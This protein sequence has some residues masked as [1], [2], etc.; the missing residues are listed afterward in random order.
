MI[1]LR[2]LLFSALLGP[3]GLS[4]AQAGIINILSDT[5][6]ATDP[7]FIETNLSFPLYFGTIPDPDNF[8]QT[9]GLFPAPEGSYATKTTFDI[10]SSAQNKFAGWFIGYKNDESLVSSD[11]TS[12]QGGSLRFWIKSGI[13]VE[14]GMASYRIDPNDGKVIYDD[15]NNDKV[16]D[17]V[18]RR[19][20]LSSLGVPLDSQWHP[21][22]I[23][24]GEFT[25]SNPTLTPARNP[26]PF[27]NDPIDLRVMKQFFIIAYPSATSGKQEVLVDNIRWDTVNPGPVRSLLVRAA[28]ALE[29]NQLTRGL[30][31]TYTAR[32]FDGDN[33]TGNEVDVWPSWRLLD[34]QTRQDLGASFLS[35]S[36]AIGNTIVVK[37][38]GDLP[39]VIRAEATAGGIT[40][41]D[42]VTLIDPTSPLAS[43][44]GIL[45]E[46]V[47]GLTLDTN[48]KLALTSP[49]PAIT[50]TALLEDPRENSFH[51][52]INY[53]IPADPG[54]G[55]IFVHAGLDPLSSATVNL[56]AFASG[57][58]RFWVKTTRD[59]LISMRSSN[60]PAGQESKVSLREFTGGAP[61]DGTWIP[62]T[63]PMARFAN[64][65]YG[66]T[67]SVDLSR[68]KVF[69]SAIIPEA[70]QG[71][72]SLDNVRLDKILPGP[73]VRIRLDPPS[74]NTVVNVEQI[75]K[76]LATD[77]NGNPVDIEPVWS[78]TGSIGRLS[79]T[80]GPLIH[81]ISTA[82]GQEILTATAGPMSDSGTI[83]VGTEGDLTQFEV[84]T[85]SNVAGDI[86]TF[87]ANAAQEGKITL[88]QEKF[89]GVL[90]LR[91]D[92]K[93]DPAKPNEI[94]GWFVD[95]GKVNLPGE[96]PETK[97]M[98]A[99]AKGFLSFTI[100]TSQDVPLTASIR[101]A[102]IPAE[103]GSP[104]V[105]FLSKAGEGF[106]NITRPFS[107]FV[108]PD[109]AALDFS[110]IS[111][112]FSIAPS[113]AVPDLQLWVGNVVWIT[114]DPSAFSEAKVL[115]GLQNKQTS[116]GLVQSFNGTDNRAATYDQGLAALSYLL[117]S[118]RTSAE[119]IFNAFAELNS[120]RPAGEG[121]S[122]FA[123]AYD[124][125][126]KEP[127]TSNGD[128]QKIAG[129]NAWLLVA[130]NR[131]K[132]ATGNAS[133]D[134]L[135]KE[136]A[137]WIL[138][139]QDT[140]GGI[141][142][143]NAKTKKSTEGNLSAI[144]ALVATAV[145]T[146][147]Q[148]YLQA[149]NRATAWLAEKMYRPA[150]KRFLVGT[151]V[152]V[153]DKALDVYSWALCHF[154]LFQE[155]AINDLQLDL[156]GILASAETDFKTSHTSTRTNKL[157]EGFDFNDDKDAVWLEGTGQMVLAYETM[158]K[159]DQARHFVDQLELAIFSLSPSSQGI[160]Y[161]SNAGTAYGGWIMNDTDPA[162]SSM[163][164]YLFSKR[165]FNPFSAQAFTPVE[166]PEPPEPPPPPPPEPPP[167]PVS[168]TVGPT[169]TE[170]V[171]IT[172]AD[173][174]S[175]SIPPNSVSGTVVIQ[176]ER[177]PFD[178]P[179]VPDGNGPAKSRRPSSAYFLTP[180]GIQF[181]PPARLTLAYDD[182]N[183]DGL[184]D[185][186][187]GQENTL[188]I[189][190]W[191]GTLWEAV[192]QDRTQD[193]VK[194]TLSVSITHFSIYAV[195]PTTEPEPPQPPVSV[196]SSPEQTRPRKIFTPNGDGVNE[197]AIFTGL[198]SLE[199]NAAIEIFDV[200]GRRIQRLERTDQWDGRDDDGRLVES[201]VYIYQYKVQGERLSG[202]IG[203]AR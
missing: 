187:G 181:S 151:D 32:G 22:T 40:D 201:G 141:F 107:D 101:S 134:A 21:V 38:T 110:E 153:T 159:Q 90:F 182:F 16:L 94:P 147:D 20:K 202:V 84:F 39:S 140:D 2:P 92:I 95:V 72:F 186:T 48:S 162:V 7:K 78:L 25:S 55:G 117:Y 71:S 88:T 115:K 87:P 130:L 113:Q 192:T 112:F 173:G 77:S 128:S 1:K 56:S 12:F 26:S 58:L 54:F 18:S 155:I 42:P 137:D 119:K 143:D 116:S 190:F 125:Q 111:A 96:T 53:N 4:L 79:N 103:Q 31:A 156:E 10:S 66:G 44:Y 200:T 121:F 74:L 13:D 57:S 126:T 144:A 108:S 188:G 122:G 67:G 176:M 76:A 17:P 63:I 29:N 124:A 139:L 49:P 195:F 160:P 154:G 142:Y 93:T 50:V 177:V 194:N 158:G 152:P 82:Q 184:D 148:A 19:F 27:R 23:P 33:R 102:N 80:R 185:R 104:A 171:T 109:Q 30:S 97:D 24:I 189:F 157:V 83:N 161:A 166:P 131:Y 9:V 8:T 132:E 135:A 174:S 169:V 150:E 138:S 46:S 198:L 168:G 60:V 45:S 68:V 61:L 105:Q 15:V 127:L 47:P 163:A 64:P 91:A 70:A 203:V 179:R 14:V 193:F 118:D 172:L 197:T 183:N 75:F 69:F 28:A 114:T 89:D 199:P 106:H 41:S 180:D 133:F 43:K 129:D 81:F 146:K 196:A 136:M 85:T 170:T 36:P 3:F 73:A 165:H 86:G 65:L 5:P 11:I 62:V 100:K 164:W 34:D 99:Y 35:P 145:Q 6:R 51:H 178:D 52:Q 167:P 120:Q 191:N 149:A 175:I 59:I 98:S 123:R 37:N